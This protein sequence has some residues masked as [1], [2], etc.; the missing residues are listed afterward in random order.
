MPTL[1][2][3]MAQYDHEHSNRWNKILHGFGIPLVIASLIL[4][5]MLHWRAALPLLVLG[6]IL[7][8]AG[9]FIEGNNPAFFRGAI[10]FL[11]GPLW[12]TKEIKD[13]V[14]GRRKDSQASR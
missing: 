7:L 9:H 10:Y 5:V 2:E 8:F 12:V 3:Y 4:L 13:T 1:A 14:W 6:W 11:V